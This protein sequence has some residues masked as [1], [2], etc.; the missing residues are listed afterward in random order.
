MLE[1]LKA[2]E[3]E[4]ESAGEFLVEIKREFGGGDQ[5]SLKVAEL[6]RIEQEGR[7]MEKFVQDF[8]RVARR[9]GYEICPL[10]KEF[11]HDMNRVIRWKLMEAENQPIIIDAFWRQHGHGQRV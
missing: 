4:Y 5:E 10:I 1:D 11:K 3:M 9:S 8:K 6:K 7:I 2:G